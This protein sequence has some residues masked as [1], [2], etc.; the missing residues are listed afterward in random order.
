MPILGSAQ[1]CDRRRWHSTRT[2]TSSAWR[3]GCSACIR[4]RCGSTSGSGLV[5]PTPHDR[6]HAALLARRARAPQGSS[7]GSSTTAGINLAGVQRLLSIAEVVQRIRPLMRDEALSARDAR[8]RLVAGARRARAGCSA[9]TE[10]W[11]SRTT[12]RRSAS[13]RRPPRRRSSRRT[14]SWRAS[15]TRTSI[16]ATSRPR[17][18]FKEIN[19]AYEVLGDP[20]EAEEVRRARRQLAACTSR[21]ARRRP[22]AG[23]PGGAWNVNFGGGGRAAAS[24]R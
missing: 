18:R 5:Q 24:A 8:R 9:S 20:D 13:R 23:Q 4:R 14:G 21:P 19:E 22:G 15:T 10:R 12:T 7:S 17:R 11:T 6:Q 16:R 2:S 1:L 3:R